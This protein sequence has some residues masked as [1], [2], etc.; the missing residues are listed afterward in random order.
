V[1]LRSDQQN[2]PAV[3]TGLPEVRFAPKAPQQKAP[4]FDHL[5]GAAQQRE[6]NGDAERLGGLEVITKSNLIG[7][8]TGMS[9]GFGLPTLR[10]PGPLSSMLQLQRCGRASPCNIS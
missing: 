4:L 7:C 6:R 3:A 10:S 1:R 8:S 9:A 2:P 5:V